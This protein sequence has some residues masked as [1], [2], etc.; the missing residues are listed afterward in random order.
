VSDAPVLRLT[1]RDAIKIHEVVDVGRNLPL[2]TDLEN[3]M[4]TATGVEQYL[5]P[6][7]AVYRRLAQSGWD[8]N[9]AGLDRENALTSAVIARDAESIEFLLQRG[10]TVT[11]AALTSAAFQGDVRILSQL[12]EAAA[13]KPSSTIFA[14]M[15][16]AAAGNDKSGA[17]EFL[18]KSGGDVN[19]RSSRDGSTPLFAAVMNGSL[20]NVNLLLSRGADPN[21]RDARGR[22]PLWYAATAT[23]TGMITALVQRGAE[24]NAQDD[25][26]A[27]PLMRAADLCYTWDIRALLDAGANPALAARSGRTALQAN[28]ASPGD[29]KCA[30]SARLL[31]QA[32]S[33][34]RR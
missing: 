14:G 23:N 20:A 16:A 2:L 21:V 5:K 26:G 30:E 3:R 8:V 25:Q 7:V 32:A 17:L 22:T 28:V 12:L 29:P 6:S 13:V 4:K 31:R 33:S 10:S 27:T 34:F 24:V 1:Y 15:L 18:L 11:H 19:A 9:T